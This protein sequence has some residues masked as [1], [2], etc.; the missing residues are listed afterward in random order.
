MIITGLIN[1][2]YYLVSLMLAIFPTSSGFGSEV[3]TAITTFGGYT[4]I[5]NT[6]V[7]LDTL[8]QI[9]TLVISYELAIFA[10]KGLRF[11][12]GYIPLVGGKG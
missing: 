11:V 6:L 1:I 2:A 12:V 3:T 5:I 8:G 10:W 9:L 4:A 7:P